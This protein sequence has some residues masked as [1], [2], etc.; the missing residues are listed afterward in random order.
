MRG[1]KRQKGNLNL[2]IPQGKLLNLLPCLNE[3]TF[4]STLSL[5]SRSCQNWHRHSWTE[6]RMS[7]SF[8]PLQDV[9]FPKSF[10]LLTHMSCKSLNSKS[11]L[12]PWQDW[13]RST[14]YTVGGTGGNKSNLFFLSHLLWEHWRTLQSFSSCPLN[15]C[16]GDPLGAGCLFLFSLANLFLC[17]L[18]YIFPSHSFVPFRRMRETFSA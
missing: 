17:D 5:Q 6:L 15:L 18:I 8:L 11:L 2:R 16:H 3:S 10:R 7:A 13:K 14:Y 1:K 12:Q 4:A 9:L